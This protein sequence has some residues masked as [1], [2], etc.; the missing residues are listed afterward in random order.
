[1]DNMTPLL[2]ALRPI[3]LDRPK[4][5][6]GAH[7]AHDFFERCETMTPAT[8]LAQDLPS[9]MEPAMR[10][11]LSLA[12]EGPA[13]PVATAL[14]ALVPHLGWRRSS[15]PQA[16]AQPTFAQ[17]HAGAVLTGKSGGFL[18]CPQMTLGISLAAPG[19]AYPEHDHPP[20]E[21][22]LL[23][24]PA[25]FRHGAT[26]WEQLGAGDTFYN[27]PGIRHAM[28]AEGEPLLALW[29]FGLARATGTVE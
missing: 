28:R 12:A 18:V 10:S 6:E 15:D 9:G 16:M 13:A 24:T 1:M 19:V 8:P 2:A 22:Y 25:A 17:G 21:L 4:D 11:A 23:L 27:T 14:A 5:Y 29:I 20:E 7:V 26:G 3:L